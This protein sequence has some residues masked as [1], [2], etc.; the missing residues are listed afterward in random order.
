M[1]AEDF[2][3]MLEKFQTMNIESQKEF[4][5]T[6]VDLIQ[7]PPKTEAEIEKNKKTWEA[8][9]EEARIF[10][11]Q[12]ARKRKYCSNQ[13]DPNL[14]HRY[15]DNMMWGMSRGESLIMWGYPQFS[16]RGEDGQILM[17]QPIPHG[18]CKWCQT[19]FKPGDPDYQEALSWGNVVM[20]G[21]VK[22][23]LRT[24]DIS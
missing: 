11:N 1:E 22:M 13:A 21:E 8:R 20:A 23:N 4:A 18:V 15:P 9:C 17:S 3:K 12:K 10:E 6:M 14:P 16:S 19:E 2:M 7:H 5:K 24:G